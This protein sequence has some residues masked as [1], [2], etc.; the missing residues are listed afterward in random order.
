MGLTGCGQEESLRCLDQQS[1][2]PVGIGDLRTEKKNSLLLSQK[3]SSQGQKEHTRQH[4]GGREGEGGRGEG[5]RA[6]K[7]RKSKLICLLFQ[8]SLAY[9]GFCTQSR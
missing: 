7:I 5:G 6:G 3:S 1:Q 9:V 2:R 8:R 4:G